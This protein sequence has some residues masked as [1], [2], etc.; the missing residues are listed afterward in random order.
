MLKGI[1]ALVA[2]LGL[3]LAAGQAGAITINDNYIGSQN[4]GYGDVISDASD[5]NHYNISSMDV[6]FG[7]GY[8]NVRVNTG[9]RQS[10]D[11]YGVQY[12]D[13]FISTNGWHPYGSAP[14]YSDNASNGEDWEFVYDTS[15]NSLYGGNFSIRTSDYF[16]GSS[17]YIYRNGQE[18][19]RGTGGTAYS[20][21]SQDL[22]HAGLGGYLEYNILLS[23]LGISG[24]ADIGLKWGMTCA[25][26]TIE[27]VAKVPEPSALML[28]GL[29]LLGLGV[30]A[31][32]RSR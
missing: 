12:G 15:A 10:D 4:H 22:S 19:Q 27:G 29:G 6:T 1:S 21:S 28:L 3:L 26:D 24:P 18:V 7:G 8:M 13:L 17:G 14:Y 2:S 23:S 9:F 16:F 30:T 31:R 32:R 11:Q 25:N 5:Y 20:G